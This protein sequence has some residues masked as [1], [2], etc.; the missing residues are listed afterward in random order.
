MSLA[1]AM[2]RSSSAPK[3]PWRMNT[4]PLEEKNKRIHA[5]KKLVTKLFYIGRMAVMI[6]RFKVCVG[7]EV[8]KKQ[9]LGSAVAV[10]AQKEIVSPTSRRVTFK[11]E[12]FLL[13]ESLGATEGIPRVAPDLCQHPN[14][15]LSLKGS[16]QHQ[17]RFLCHACLTAFKRYRLADLHPNPQRPP[18]ETDRITWG[19][20]FGETYLTA[21]RDSH[22]KQLS[23]MMAEDPAQTRPWIV[24]FATFCVM[25]ENLEASLSPQ[26]P[27]TQMVTQ[28][29]TQAAEQQIQLL[30]STQEWEDLLA[31]DD[32]VSMA[33]VPVSRASSNRTRTRLR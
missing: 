17:L 12:E 32:S 6:E 13:G 2:T 11:G 16:N 10:P 29:R 22:F 5:W 31:P 18:S 23:L 9:F 33:S 26:H 7:S 14:Q 15:E 21:S 28:I 4:P 24:R 3:D 30:E 27:V 25:R 19:T 8:Y 1:A 20:L